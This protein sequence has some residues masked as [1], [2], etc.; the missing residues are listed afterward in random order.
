MG[1]VG[2][3]GPA[4]RSGARLTSFPATLP[5]PFGILPYQ[6]APNPRNILKPVTWRAEGQDQAPSFSSPVS[7]S[8][9]H[10]PGPVLTLHEVQVSSGQCLGLA[11]IR[12]DPG[13]QCLLNPRH[14]SD[15]PPFLQ[16]VATVRRLRFGQGTPRGTSIITSCCA[17][18]HCHHL[19]H[20]GSGQTEQP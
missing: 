9:G 7:T 19:F 11:L 1:L 13:Q 17:A 15:A 18:G 20:H 3:P 2:G 10:G 8:T 12:G 6:V 4:P 14:A 5:G 16:V